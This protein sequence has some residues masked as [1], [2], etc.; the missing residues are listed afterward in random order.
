MTCD[1]DTH[2]HPDVQGAAEDVP[3]ETGGGVLGEP[4]THG[5]SREPAA[6]GPQSAEQGTGPETSVS[7]PSCHLQMPQAQDTVRVLLEQTEAEAPSAT[8]LSASRPWQLTG[9]PRVEPPQAP[10]VPEVERIMVSLSS[11]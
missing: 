7:L 10:N 6:W 11:F 1:S 4:W 5:H 2:V 9:N 8:R 3:R